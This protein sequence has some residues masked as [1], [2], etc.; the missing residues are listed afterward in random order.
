MLYNFNTLFQADYLS[1]MIWLGRRVACPT[2]ITTT[3]TTVAA[4]TKNPI[5]I[6]FYLNGSSNGIIHLEIFLYIYFTRLTGHLPTA[7]GSRKAGIL[8]CYLNTFFLLFSATPSTS[9]LPKEWRAHRIHWSSY[10]WRRETKHRYRC[11]GCKN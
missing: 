2:N 6:I 1:S 5:Q 3:T 9:I 11:L 8:Q 10:L 4:A 7:G